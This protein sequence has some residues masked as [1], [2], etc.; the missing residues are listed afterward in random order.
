MLCHQPAVATICIEHYTLCHLFSCDMLYCVTGYIR[1]VS[2]VI[3]GYNLCG[4]YFMLCNLLGAGPVPTGCV[5][6]LDTDPDVLP[7]SCGYSFVL[8]H[9]LLQ[10]ANFEQ[11]GHARVWSSLGLYVVSPVSWIYRS[12]VSCCYRWCCVTG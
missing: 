2:P 5:V 3:Y 8:Y 7:V 10:A 4:A 11:I 12:P 9:S 1:A 6:L